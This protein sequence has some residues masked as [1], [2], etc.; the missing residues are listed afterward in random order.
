MSN[1]RKQTIVI[2]ALI[3]LIVCASW[4][5]KVF[6]DNV[7][8]T[9]VIGDKVIQTNQTMNFFAESRIQNDNTLSSMK[10]DLNGIINN[11]ELG[12][13]AHEDATT[14]LIK[15]VNVSNNENKIETMVKG[16]GF[17]DALCTINDKSVEVCV[18]VSREITAAEVHQIKDIVV[19]TTKTSPSNIFVIPRQ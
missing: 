11:K 12:K 8:N 16:N 3:V 6:N 13:K 2:S 4:F 18:K 1:V 10:A 14:A 7:K 19:N 5:G 15:M 9:D 17:E